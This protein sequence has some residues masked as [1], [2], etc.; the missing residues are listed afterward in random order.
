[1]GVQS[2]ASEEG[3]G[4]GLYNVNKRLEYMHG[5]SAKLQIKSEQ[6]QGT[7]IVFT[8]PLHEKETGS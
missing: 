1:M 5:E 8:V 2:V 3:T 7:T 4:Y 6:G